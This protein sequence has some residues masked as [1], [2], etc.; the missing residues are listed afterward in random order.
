MAMFHSLTILFQLSAGWRNKAGESIRIE[1]DLFTIMVA[2]MMATFLIVQDS[3]PAD[4]IKH[5]ALGQFLDYVVHY[6]LQCDP[7]PR[8][9]YVLS[10][11]DKA[12][13]ER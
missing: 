9:R 4:R 8:I 3:D 2:V 10:N 7:L 6:N 13:E 5:S 1:I 12:W 11:I